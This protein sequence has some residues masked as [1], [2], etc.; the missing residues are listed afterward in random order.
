MGSYTLLYILIPFVVEDG[1]RMGDQSQALLLLL[2]ERAV[3]SGYIKTPP[4]W[5]TL[6]TASLVSL[7]VRRW[8]HR[9]S[10]WLHVKTA[11]LLV[12]QSSPVGI[13]P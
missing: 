12:R 10:A 3:A 11:R 9:L 6:S 8:Q 2:A 1:G 4:S 13:Y 5:N 7:T